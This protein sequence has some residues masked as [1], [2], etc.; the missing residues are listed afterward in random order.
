M[1]YNL[2]RSHHL[3]IC[4]ENRDPNDTAYQFRLEIPSNLISLNDPATQ[5]MK[6]SL[7][8]F[9][10][11]CLWFEIN[12]TNNS[13]IFT[14][15]ITNTDETITIP[16]GNY[17]FQQLALTISQLY[18]ECYCEWIQETN[19]LKFMFQ[20]NHE[21]SFIGLSYNTLGFDEIDDGISGDTIISTKSLQTRANNIMYVRINDVILAND[22]LNL[23]NFNDPHAKPSNIL[24]A[25]PV[26]ASPF[27]TIFYDNS[28]YGRDSG[29]YLSNPKLNNLNLSFTDK[30]GEY[31]D[32]ITDWNM[33]L[34]VEIFDIEDNV[35]VD[36]A[37][38]LQSINDTL[39][40]LLIYKVIR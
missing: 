37:S 24:C 15:T 14:N 3:Y 36:I 11:D 9:S 5:R 7:M 33:Q 28:V 13:F 17:T 1:A 39:R 12:N 34:L 29:I 35:M 21:I 25:I 30:N 18:P 6:V 38:T 27:T 32:Y 8:N 2:V 23:D 31:L 22:C 19:K 10:C 16:E 26:N 4:S 20:D 40:K